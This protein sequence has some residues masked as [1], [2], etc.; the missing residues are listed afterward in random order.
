MAMNSRLLRPKA[1][2][3]AAFSPASVDGLFTWWDF[4]DAAV[5]TLNGGGVAAVADKSGNGNYPGGEPRSLSQSI[6]GD[7]PL[8]N[9]TLQNGYGGAVF[10]EDAHMFTGAASDWQF[11][12][13]GTDLWSMFI[14]GKSQADG[15]MFFGDMAATA[16]NGLPGI[17]IQDFNNFGIDQFALNL[18]NGDSV[19][20]PNAT[21]S[22]FAER[23]RPSVFHFKVAPLTGAVS[24][25]L[26]I[27]TGST[28]S[29]SDT[30]ST[31]SASPDI[32]LHFG[33]DM[34]NGL[35]TFK[36]ELYEILIYRRSTALSGAEETAVV[37]YLKS[38]WGIG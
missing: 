20:Y 18:D 9:A 15:D 38:K 2:A 21:V 3:A 34:N 29:G 22:P 17:T 14:A 26:K 33:F 1:S 23:N 16:A 11:L 8:Y 27:D 19:N 6:A 37:N 4:S 5:L 30:F 24:L 32:Q 12:H 28:G 7:Q 10:D 31:N 13:F 36:G 35:N 25:S